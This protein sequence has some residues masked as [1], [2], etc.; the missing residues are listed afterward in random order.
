MRNKII[1]LCLFIVIAYF[2]VRELFKAME[3]SLQDYPSFTYKG[4]TPKSDWINY[5]TPMAKIAGSKY[6]IPW[7]AIVVQTALE[8][9]WGKSSLLKKYNNWGGIKA[10]KGEASVNLSTGEFLNG[11]NVTIVDGFKV[12]KTPYEGAMGYGSFFHENKRYATALKY[13]NDPYKF[14]EEIKKAGYAT[15]PNYVSTLHTLLNQNFA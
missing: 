9:S 12:W 1:L 10:K 7:Q 2:V 5:A 14:I 3:L 6:G 13:P 11:Q 15:A 4:K 8:T